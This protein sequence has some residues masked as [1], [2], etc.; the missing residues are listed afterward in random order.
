MT[1]SGNPQREEPRMQSLTPKQF[2][3]TRKFVDTDFGRIAY[4]ERGQG[5]TA[6]FIHG[7]LLNGYQWRHQLTGLSDLR[8]VIALDTLGMGHTQMRPGQP[9]GMKRQAGMFAAF[10]DAL[11]IDK[12]DLVGNDS[13]GG[14]AQVFAANHPDR[15]RTLT[16]TNCEVHDYDDSAPAFVQFR[17]G[18]ASGALVKLLV[19]AAT[20]GAIGKKAMKSVYQDVTGVPDE[21]IVTYFAPLVASQ[22]RIDQMLA[23]VAANTNRDLVAIEAKLKALAAPA[24]VL[25]GTADGFFP[26]KQAYWLRDNLPNV[27]E[28]VELE[29]APVFWPEERPGFLNEKLRAFW[30]RHP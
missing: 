20:D 13:G 5:P 2:H 22:E 11:G 27:E 25:W 28:V 23:Y 6:L 24:M 10:V 17:Q 26:V 30:T 12:L 4:V 15:I 18:I 1:Y 7:A 8:R 29:G 3:E 16:L 19:A 14:A 21:A 9:L